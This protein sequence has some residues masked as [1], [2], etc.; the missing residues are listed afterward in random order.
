MRLYELEI[1]WARTANE[2]RYLQWELLA[3]DEVL[4]VFRTAR[5]ETLA[6]LFDGGRREFR[7]WAGTFGPQVA[8]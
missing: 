7:D 1:S 6:V 2:H 3:C 5:V 4:A 8:A